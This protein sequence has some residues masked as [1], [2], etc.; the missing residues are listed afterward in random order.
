MENQ[1]SVCLYSPS[2]A[3]VTNILVIPIPSALFLYFP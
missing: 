3:P 1:F 2:E